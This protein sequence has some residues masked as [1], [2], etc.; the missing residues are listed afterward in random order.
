MGKVKQ[1]GA[2]AGRAGRWL[3]LTSCRLKTD[4]PALYFAVSV[5]RCSLPKVK[6]PGSNGAN[7][8]RRTFTSFLLL[9]LNL[10]DRLDHSLSSANG[11][12]SGCVQALARLYEKAKHD[13][14]L[15][16]TEVFYERDWLEG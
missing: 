6:D 1:R 5:L 8:C 15:L 9:A 12:H 2:N 11:R 16:V 14:V 3:M 7:R 4:L 10:F 13:C